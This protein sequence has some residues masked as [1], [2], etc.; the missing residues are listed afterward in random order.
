[1]GQWKTL[2]G[3]SGWEVWVAASQ[4]E[5][6]AMV[7][8]SDFMI[9]VCGNGCELEEVQGSQRQVSRELPSVSLTPAS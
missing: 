6:T 7:W 3:S 5:E 9:W 1:M 8:A 4:E 2:R